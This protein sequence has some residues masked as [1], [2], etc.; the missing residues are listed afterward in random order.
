MNKEDSLQFMHERLRHQH[1][2]SHGEFR[3]HPVPTVTR[4]V[5]I[6]LEQDESQVFEHVDASFS[7]HCL[8]GGVW[9]T[10]EDD[11]ADAILVTGETFH[12]SREGAMHVYAVTAVALEIQFEDE[13]MQH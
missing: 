8:R 4:R 3:L 11:P 10:L 2:V 6:E 12:V 5:T 9:I 7:V 13:V 1:S